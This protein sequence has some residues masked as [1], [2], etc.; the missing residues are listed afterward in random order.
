M[1]YNYLYI[2]ILGIL[3]K[4]TDPSPLADNLTKSFNA[5]YSL[6]SHFGKYQVSMKATRPPR[7]AGKFPEKSRLVTVGCNMMQSFPAFL[8]R[9]PFVSVAWNVV[10]WLH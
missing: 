10:P 7:V 8:G 5:L 4:I 6:C 9:S 3:H 2:D 1:I